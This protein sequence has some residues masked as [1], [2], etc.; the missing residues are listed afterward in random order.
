MSKWDVIVIGAGNGGLSAATTF[1]K[2]GK[3]VLILEKH[4]VPGGFATSFKRGRFEFEASLHE[5]SS[6]GCVPGAG[7]IRKIFEELGI[8]DKIEWCRIPDAYRMI[9]LSDPD[10]VDV[11]MPFGVGA[12]I[13][14]MEQYVPGSRAKMNKLFALGES[15]RKTGDFFGNI[16]SVNPQLV[17]DVFEDHM[18]FV[19][20][21]SYSTNEVLKAAGIPKKA[22]DIFNAYWCYLG[23][24]C[25][26]LS[27]IHYMGLVDRYI[28]FG[29]VCAKGRSHELSCAFQDR[30]EELGGTIYFNSFVDKIVMKD[31]NA[32]GVHIKDR[33]E[34]E[35]AD[36]I[37]CNSAPHNAISKM[38]DRKDLP[39]K[40]IRHTNARKFAGR[41]FTMFLG[42][43]KS[44][45]ELGINEHCYMIYD[46]ADTV[47]QVKSMANIESNNA[48]ATCCLNRAVP[49]C[50]P[51]GTTI[52]YFT[53]LY[54]EDCWSKVDEKDYVKTKEYVADKMIDNFEKATGT[55]IRDSIEEIEIA[56]PATYARY[57]DAPQGTIYGY[58]AE[59]WDGIVHRLLMPAS[60]DLINNLYFVGG[61]GSQLLGFGSAYTNGYQTANRIMK[62][63]QKEAQK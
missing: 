63:Q 59:K 33:D 41:G 24:D 8:H 44:P 32:V 49:D 31:G 52:L 47:Q 39:E 48:Q 60:E 5:L 12:Y 19:R 20:I 10:K 37:V 25:D 58:S 7:A 40:A 57:T 34:I 3:K 14:K 45:D 4:N 50:S 11:T 53:T 28:N 23:V 54:T 46:T 61:Y 15:L 16:N 29:A 30:F 55:K 35:Y 17:Q 9:T 22:R 42:L 26:T 36:C 1:A 27:F 21:A 38:I 13:D 2:A 62:K 56:T 6:Y 43:D 51:E 18:D